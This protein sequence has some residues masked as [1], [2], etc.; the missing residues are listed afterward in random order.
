MLRSF[1]GSDFIRYL[2]TTSNGDAEHLPSLNEL[3]STL[4]VSVAALREQLEVAKALGLVEVRPR[5]G[6][7]RLP[8]TFFPAVQQSLTYALHLDRSHFAAF[9]D[10]RNHLEVAYWDQAVRLLTAEDLLE[11]QAMMVQAWEKLHGSP[12]HVP[13]EEHRRL[14]LM[15]YRRLE[16][17]FVLGLLE[18]YWDAY[19]A[20]GLN[21]YT[22]LDHLQQVWQFHQQMVDAVCAGDFEMGRQALVTH[23]DL[24]FL[25][26]VKAG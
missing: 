17:P 4:G 2:L 16:N 26:P 25:K 8:Y 24:L 15:I 12:V 7:R 5:T 22:D 19:E 21:V 23:Q 13:H 20:I 9:A 11:L 10:L 6:I 1:P 3:S 18:A 14:H